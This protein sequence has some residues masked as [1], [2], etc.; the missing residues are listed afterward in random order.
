MTAWYRH[1]TH[2]RRCLRFIQSMQ[3]RGFC[4][5]VMQAPVFFDDNI[6]AFLYYDIGSHWSYTASQKAGSSAISDARNFL[7]ERLTTYERSRSVL[8]QYWSRRA[9]TVT[10]RETE[11]GSLADPFFAIGGLLQKK[12]VDI[13][14]KPLI[15][16]LGWCPG[17]LVETSDP[18]GQPHDWTTLKHPP[19][20]PSFEGTIHI[21]NI[22]VKDY[23]HA[24]Y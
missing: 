24:E 2:P 7:M 18:M 23:F 4:F 9:R 1:Q 16:I 21:L 19:G 22:S 6:F 11:T 5:F 20:P 13:F 14:G 10:L 3:D 12:V 17:G 15:V 8:R